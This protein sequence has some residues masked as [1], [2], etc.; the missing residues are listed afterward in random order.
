MPY[1][2]LDMC[3]RYRTAARVRLA[4][5]VSRA[6]EVIMSVDATQ[7]SV[8]TRD[9]GGGSVLA[10]RECV[11]R[12]PVGNDVSHPQIQREAVCRN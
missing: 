9:L 10:F 1:R 3:G 8:A 11:N 6:Y 7:I 2:Q 4:A 5:A 12:S